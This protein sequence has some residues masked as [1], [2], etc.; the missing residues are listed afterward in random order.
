MN[1]MEVSVL[2]ETEAIGRSAIQK[3]TLRVIPVMGLGYGIA[4]M[5]RVHISFASLSMNR[6][7]HF[8]AAVYGFG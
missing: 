3:A 4:Y 6:D 8:S 7:L 1:Q 5:D 2:S